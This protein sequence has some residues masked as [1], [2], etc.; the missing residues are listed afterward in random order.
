L[1]SVNDLHFTVTNATLAELETPNAD[2]NL[3]VADILEPGVAG[4][5]TGPVDV[6]LTAAT[7]LPGAFMM[8]GTVLAGGLGVSGWRKRRQ[9]GPASSI[10]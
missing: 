6:S 2:G 8:F 1:G 9:R 7:P 3:F 4:G 10:A 5:P